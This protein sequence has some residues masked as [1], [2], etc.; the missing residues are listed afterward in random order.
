VSDDPSKI[1]TGQGAQIN[2]GDSFMVDTEA[3]VWVGPLPGQTTGVV[4]V[5]E[6]FNPTSGEP[7][8]P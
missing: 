5:S 4:Q 7:L 3:P 6:C 1:N 2:P 8:G